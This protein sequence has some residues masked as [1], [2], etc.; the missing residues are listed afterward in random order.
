MSATARF[1]ASGGDLLPDRDS[2]IDAEAEQHPEPA[3]GQL[4][5]VTGG[6]SRGG[7]PSV[8]AH[9]DV[10][11][12]TVTA[13]APGPAPGRRGAGPEPWRGGN[14]DRRAAPPHRPT[15]GL[16]RHRRGAP[17]RSRPATERGMIDCFGWSPAL[18]PPRPTARSNR[19]PPSLR[20]CASA[21]RVVERDGTS[22]QSG[23]CWSGRKNSASRAGRRRPQHRRG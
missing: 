12:P 22:H 14:L 20:P 4:I 3:P 7:L 11:L 23:I 8:L 5:S 16:G 18:P 9:L 17:A 15:I 13:H 1:A 19:S 2:P 21:H 10:W 6:R